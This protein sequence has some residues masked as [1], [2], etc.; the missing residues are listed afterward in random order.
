MVTHGVAAECV[1]LPARIVRSPL[2]TLLS[3][4]TPQVRM[5]LGPVYA[6]SSAP[7]GHAG[8]RGAGIGRSRVLERVRATLLGEVA[9]DESGDGDRERSH[10]GE[11]GGRVLAA[12]QGGGTHASL[13]R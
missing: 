6:V 11:D 13:L 7:G 4:T 5:V 8:V 9:D 10:D 3:M 2:T 1:P 12:R